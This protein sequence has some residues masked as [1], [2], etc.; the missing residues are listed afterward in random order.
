MTGLSKTFGRGLLILALA[1]CAFACG[2]DDGGGG[3]TDVDGGAGTGGGGAGTGGSGD[4]GGAGSGGG[5]IAACV[6]AATPLA[7]GYPAACLT[8]ACTEGLDEAVACNNLT[9]CWDLIGCFAMNCS[10]LADPTDTAMRTTCATENCADFLGGAGAATPLGV[11]LTGACSSDCVA[12]APVDGGG[13]TG[14]GDA[15]GGDTDGGS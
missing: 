4:D 1:S 8:C 15:D 7:E 14:G 11:V 3:T 6:T 13:G 5:D 2:D 10:D 12:A 9:S